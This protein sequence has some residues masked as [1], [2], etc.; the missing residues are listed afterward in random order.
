M[1]GRR[2]YPSYEQV[3]A[4]VS[5][6]VETVKVVFDPAIIPYDTLLTVFFA[7]HDPT[8]LDKQGADTGEEY[9]SVIFPAND[10]Q[11]QQARAYIKKLTDD[12]V[13]DKE[14]VTE[15]RPGQTFRIAEG[16]HQ[17]FYRQHPNKPYCTIVIN[18]K[19]QKLRKSFA[20]LLKP[21]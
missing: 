17:D 14:I 21:E 7:S 20:H 5:G 15:I 12:K 9:R 2:D 11:E 19:I 4:G 8:S 18:P 6:H 10:E 16:Y 1:G 3:A 13:Y